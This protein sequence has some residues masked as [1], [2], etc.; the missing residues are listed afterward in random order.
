[1]ANSLKTNEFGDVLVNLKSHLVARKDTKGLKLLKDLEDDLRRL[2][3][4]SDRSRSKQKLW[5]RIYEIIKNLHFLHTVLEK[6]TDQD[7]TDL[8]E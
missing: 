5:K 7:I 2:D 1:M 8:L 6:I 4:S 3:I